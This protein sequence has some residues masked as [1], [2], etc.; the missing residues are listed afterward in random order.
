MLVP[1]Q[2]VAP[3]EPGSYVLRIGVVDELTTWFEGEALLPVDVGVPVVLTFPRQEAEAVRQAL[4]TS[5][6]Y[7]EFG[8]GGSTILAAETGVPQIMSV[9]T[10][11][12]FLTHV[13][14][15]VAKK[16]AGVRLQAYGHRYRTDL[17]MGF[18][19]R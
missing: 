9:E 6:T 12:D 2:L 18:P 15:L 7:L 13:S 3:S 8:A 11:H 10:D 16:A 19:C 4:R 5:H 1:L 14:E 17:F